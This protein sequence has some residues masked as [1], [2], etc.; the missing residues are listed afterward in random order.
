MPIGW[1]LALKAA[2]AAIKEFIAVYLRRKADADS[3]AR[4]Q[5]AAQDAADT[6][7]EGQATE[8]ADEI[9]GLTDDERR[10][11]AEHWQRMRDA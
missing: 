3:G 2:W 5:R 6:K 8:K 1:R 9:A 11:R 7:A 4:D 10:A